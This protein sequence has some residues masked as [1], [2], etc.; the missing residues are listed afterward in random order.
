MGNL[1]IETI[2][3]EFKNHCQV[4]HSRHKSVNN[5]MID[6]L[7]SLTA[8]YLFLKNPHLN[9]KKVNDCQLFLNITFRLKLDF[10][11]FIN[12]FL[13]FFLVFRPFSYLEYFIK[14]I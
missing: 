14:E 11:S 10:F 8:Y 6:I 13:E 9:Y 3:D 1:Q 7:G 12:T 4:K 2:N 5:F